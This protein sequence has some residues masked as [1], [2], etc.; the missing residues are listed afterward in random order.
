MVLQ[1]ARRRRNKGKRPIL[2]TILK[3]VLLTLLLPIASRATPGPSTFSGSHEQGK[4]MNQPFADDPGATEVSP[5]IP[6]A[7][8]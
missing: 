1:L 4:D 8:P 3:G 5:V 6:Q 2:L 7:Q